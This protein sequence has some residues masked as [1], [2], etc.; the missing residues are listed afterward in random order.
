[1]LFKDRFEAGEKLCTNLAA[2]TDA[3]VLAI[4]RGGV[5]VACPMAERLQAPLGVIAARKLASPNRPETAFG[6][7]TPDGA[8]VMSREYAQA[9]ELS[10]S[11]ITKIKQETMKEAVRR[12]NIYLTE[13][14]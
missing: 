12:Q 3:V 14:P 11:E 2:I 6:A 7:M 1:M 9:L 13:N 8:F 5:E 4:P 10:D